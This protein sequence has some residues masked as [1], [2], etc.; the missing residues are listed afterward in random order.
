MG[1][2]IAVI[3]TYNEV[4]NLPTLTDALLNLDVVTLH[5]LVVDDNSPDG[6]GV[7]A[8]KLSQENPS[9][10]SVLH[11]RKKAG[12]GSAYIA[13]FR[14][15]IN[16]GM[17]Y[18][19]QMDA[20][21]SHQPKYIVDMMGAIE[22]HDLVIGSRYIP[23]GKVDE[24]WPIHRKML[25]GFAN[26]IYIRAILN[27]PVRDAT[28]GFR[29][30]RREILSRLNLDQISSSGYAFQIEMAYAAYQLGCRIKEVPIYFPERDQGKSK[31]SFSIQL[32]GV[33]KVWEL[34]YR[35]RKIRRRA[36][37]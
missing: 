25:S 18:I 20:D 11:R 32:E 12:L 5:L 14:K 23:G 7:L 33:T 15:A 8:E 4:E 13:G 31:I 29:L 2:T 28:S 16:M 37:K 34:K 21:L 36:M 10:I 22:N 17:D 27:F 6:T 9:R 30:W 19:I 1:R 24:D 3:P 26:Q 35:N